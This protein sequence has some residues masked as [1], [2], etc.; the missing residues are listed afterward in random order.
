MTGLE[1]LDKK[2]YD[3]YHDPKNKE[4]LPL[5]II[6][7]LVFCLFNGAIL[8]Q[9]LLWWWYYDYCKTNNDKLNN[10]KANLERRELLLERK[11]KILSGE[12]KYYDKYK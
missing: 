4:M 11:R 5:V 2:I 3:T 12:L 8:F 7:T 6:L 9:I 10:N 1:R